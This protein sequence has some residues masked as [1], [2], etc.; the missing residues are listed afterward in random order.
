MK[1]VYS[2]PSMDAYHI[3]PETILA[4]SDGSNVNKNSS[5]YQDSY[6]SF[7]D[8]MGGTTNDPD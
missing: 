6:N 1:K 7:V 3:K 8:G 4:G 5:P 2:K